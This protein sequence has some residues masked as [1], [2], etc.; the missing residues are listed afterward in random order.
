MEWTPIVD[1]AYNAD[2]TVPAIS[3]DTFAVTIQLKDFEGNNLKVPAV[4]HAHVTTDAAGLLT[5][6]LTSEISKTS[7]GSGVVNI[8]LAKYS[9]QLISDADGY[10]TIDCTDTGTTDIYLVLV[11][12]DGSLVVSGVMAFT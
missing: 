8:L 6:V 9:W 12:P 10:I 4:I 3:S 5:E 2:I 7:S 1:C 11:M